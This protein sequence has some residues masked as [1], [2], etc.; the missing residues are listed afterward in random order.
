[1]N[2]YKKFAYYYDEVMSGMNYTKWFN[3]IQPY[4]NPDSSILDLAC[5]SG[6]FAIMLKLKGFHVEGLDLSHSILE[7]ASE[8]A[9]INHLDIPFYEM[10]M[11]HFQ[12]PKKYDVITCFFDSINFIE[13][14]DDIDALI[15]NVYQHL[16]PKGYF[17]FDIF[18]KKMLHEYQHHHFEENNFTYHIDWKTERV[19]KTKL[20]HHIKIQEGDLSIEES[21]YEYY[22]KIKSLNWNQFKL[23]KICG[24]FNNDLKKCDERILVVLQAT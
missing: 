9:K 7:I 24:D 1:M 19:N 14:K 8:K 13:K 18:S 6:T 16:K 20:K 2:E 23:L 22:H 5:G 12:L 4:L 15:A 17:I 21:Y 3:F 10:D 11:I